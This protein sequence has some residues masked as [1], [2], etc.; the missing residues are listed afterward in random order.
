MQMGLLGVLLTFISYLLM[1]SATQASVPPSIDINTSSFTI[2]S[3]DLR[4]TRDLI[5]PRP[6]SSWLEQRRNSFQLSRIMGIAGK[7]VATAHRVSYTIDPRHSSLAL[8]N[9]HT[10]Q[11][12]QKAAPAARNAADPAALGFLGLGLIALGLVRRRKKH[13]QALPGAQHEKQPASHDTAA[14]AI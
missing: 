14:A 13:E 3:S 2:S 10:P 12:A 1:L 8:P 5:P 4:I 11:T 9:R 6:N 7:P